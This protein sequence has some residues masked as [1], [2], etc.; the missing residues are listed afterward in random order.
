MNA[1]VKSIKK[2]RQY[3]L[4]TSE[5][6]FEAKEVITATGS[7]QVIP[8]IA[9]LAE[10]I[11]KGKAVTSKE[12]F[13]LKE[14]PNEILILGAGVVGIEI[15]SFFTDLG[16]Q[17]TLID[18]RIRILSDITDD[19]FRF[20]MNELEKQGMRFILGADVCE[21]DSE[22]G[23]C[24][25]Y[26]KNGEIDEINGD[27]LIIAT[28]RKPVNRFNDVEGIYVC[29]DANGKSMLAHTAMREAVV[30][31]HKIIGEKELVDYSRIPSVIYSSPE[32]SW[33]GINENKNSVAKEKKLAMDFSSR[34]VI[35]SDGIKGC[36][37]IIKNTEGEKVG[38]QIVG[39]GGSELIPFVLA[40][41]L[42]DYIYPH[43]SICEI[44]REIL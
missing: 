20:Y 5:G 17:V 44:L 41:N 2:D 36:I 11:Q 42:E 27:C 6:I 25:L 40:D 21:V 10:A 4:E 3:G 22:D 7:E 34:Y 16:K 19:I 8:L 39:D 15:A 35:D 1:E 37:K 30:A 31:V 29:G 33:V 26:Q 38:C 28:G 13:K 23:V 24:L 9:G 32:L 14:F 43:P 12:F 18:N